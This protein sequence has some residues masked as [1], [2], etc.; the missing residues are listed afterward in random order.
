MFFD[1]EHPIPLLQCQLP[2][3]DHTYLHYQQYV[4]PEH[5]EMRNWIILHI[6]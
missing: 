2:F 4:D 5:V 6:L 3:S 1:L